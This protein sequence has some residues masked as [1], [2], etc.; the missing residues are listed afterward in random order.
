MR[1]K[2][3]LIKK[4]TNPQMKSIFKTLLLLVCLPAMLASCGDDEP[5][6]Q[7]LSGEDTNYSINSNFRQEVLPTLQAG[8]AWTASVGYGTSDTGWLAIDKS[9]GE[10]GDVKITATIQSNPSNKRRSATVTVTCHGESVRFQFSQEANSSSSDDPS[11]SSGAKISKIEISTYDSGLNI[12]AEESIEF[13][14]DADKKLKGAAYHSLDK[15]SASIA[16]HDINV[17]LTRTADA[18][19]YTFSEIGMP[20]E[21]YQASLTDGRITRLGDAQITYDGNYLKKLTIGEKSWIFGAAANVMEVGTP[22][23]TQTI[24]LNNLVKLNE[25]NTFNLNAIALLT[26]NRSEM[27]KYAV[28]TE[29]GML[30]GQWEYFINTLVT[31][32]DTYTYNYQYDST[33]TR[34]KI[35]ILYH[36][37]D[38]L[39][40]AQEKVYNI[41]YAE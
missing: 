38:Q 14:Y 24:K 28:F 31:G 9:S 2:T 13:A 1:I 10:K 36:R 18:V 26:T 25:A 22:D 35:I 34:I 23:G 29:T 12:V 40:P 5:K 33:K 3:L 20:D 41:T 11:V 4:I 27:L 30:G 32:R 17:A 37:V 39:N 21:V 16:E 7:W 6:S 15:Q 19:T 8:D